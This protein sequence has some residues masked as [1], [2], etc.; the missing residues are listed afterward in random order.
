MFLNSHAEQLLERKRDELIGRSLW[1]ELP[2]KAGS[3][4]QRLRETGPDAP[5]ASQFTEWHP[6]LIRW[7]KVNA[8]PTA[9]GLAVRKA[10]ARAAGW[11]SA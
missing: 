10:A 8:R 3:A 4:F 2:V 9:D 7:F 1:E 11:D 5:A 6:P